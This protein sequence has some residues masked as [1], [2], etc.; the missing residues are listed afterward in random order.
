MH[1][2]NERILNSLVLRTLSSIRKNLYKTYKNVIHI[3]NNI[4]FEQ[5]YSLT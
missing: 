2:I 4:A 5:F 3:P 1:I